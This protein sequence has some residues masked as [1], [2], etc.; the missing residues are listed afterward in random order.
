MLNSRSRG[1][2]AVDLDLASRTGPRRRDSDWGGRPRSHDEDVAWA[3]KRAAVTLAAATIHARDGGTG[4]HSDD[5]VHLCC[6]IADDLGVYG[7]DRAELLA[8]AQLHDI[9]KVAVPT[10][11]LNK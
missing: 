10:E 2:F 7:Q 1:A 3:A 4:T 9:G 6:A 8:A 5:V 11:V